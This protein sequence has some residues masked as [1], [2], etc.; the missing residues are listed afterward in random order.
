MAEELN[1]LIRQQV[2]NDLVQKYPKIKSIMGFESE[3][4]SKSSPASK[5][6]TNKKN[7]FQVAV[8]P[9]MTRKPRFTFYVRDRHTTD[10]DSAIRPGPGYYEAKKELLSKKWSF[11]KSERHLTNPLRGGGRYAV[12]S[13]RGNLTPGPIYTRYTTMYGENIY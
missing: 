10:F 3:L 8:Y 11:G 1:P 12:K 6:D 5:A 4:R 13:D 7:T 9:D 2:I